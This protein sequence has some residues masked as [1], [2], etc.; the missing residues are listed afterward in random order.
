MTP[1]PVARSTWYLKPLVSAAVQLTILNCQAL[2]HANQS[3]SSRF[4][5]VAHGG[6]DENEAFCG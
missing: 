5:T 2:L 1:P 4:L 3:I 6:E